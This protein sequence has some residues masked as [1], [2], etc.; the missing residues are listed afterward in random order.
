[1][2]PQAHM[3]GSVEIGTIISLFGREASLLGHAIFPASGLG[4]C[5]SRMAQVA[6]KICDFS[7]DRA[8]PQGR[9]AKIPCQQ[10]I[11]PQSAA[12]TLTCRPGIPPPDA[13]PRDGGRHRTVFPGT[14]RPGIRACTPRAAV[15]P[16]RPDRRNP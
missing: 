14:C 15:I 12:L 2:T 10:G 3:T 5:L 11:S 7:A 13:A 4:N 1:M 9:K 8:L 16:A 6:E